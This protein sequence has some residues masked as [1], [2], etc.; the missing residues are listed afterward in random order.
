[1]NTGTALGWPHEPTPCSDVIWI[2]VQKNVRTPFALLSLY[3]KQVMEKLQE[4]KAAVQEAD[5]TTPEI[6]SKAKEPDLS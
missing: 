3:R 2:Q 5:R 1:L 6:K 4:K